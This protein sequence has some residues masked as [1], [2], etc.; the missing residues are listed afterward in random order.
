VS[1]F[2]PN[3]PLTVSMRPMTRDSIPAL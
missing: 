1:L 3:Q 2:P